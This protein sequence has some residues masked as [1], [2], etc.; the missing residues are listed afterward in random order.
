MP[1]RKF[2]GVEEMEGNTWREPGDQELFRAIRATW[3]FAQR[4][5][6]PH[7]P[8]GVYKH[9]SIEDAEKLREEWERANFEAHQARLRERRVGSGTGRK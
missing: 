3:E 4:T 8:P 1:V 6:R 5:L 7:F 2:R 9:R